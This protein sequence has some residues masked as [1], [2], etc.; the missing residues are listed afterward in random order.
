MCGK[1]TRTC[2]RK[3]ERERKKRREKEKGNHKTG[4]RLNRG[5]EW[6][7]ERK[8]G[9]V[10]ALTNE[11]LINL[12]AWMYLIPRCR[13]GMRTPKGPVKSW[14]SSYQRVNPSEGT[15]WHFLRAAPA[16]TLSSAWSNSVSFLAHFRSL[17]FFSRQAEGNHEG[18]ER[19]NGDDKG[20]ATCV[21]NS[22][23]FQ[24]LALLTLWLLCVVS[25]SEKYNLKNYTFCL[26]FC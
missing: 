21:A 10:V 26:R 4:K 24:L 1:R 13:E 11:Y 7:R 20:V 9:Q 5:W 22:Q 17:A 25:S 12:L 3:K 16:T 14:G 6:R 15:L 19:R 8:A 23:T 18:R 2:E